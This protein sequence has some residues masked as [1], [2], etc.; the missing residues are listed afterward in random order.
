VNVIGV[1]LVENIMFIR[2][3]LC[4]IEIWSVGRNLD[5]NAL[6]VLRNQNGNLILQPILSVNICEV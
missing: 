3:V 4:D 5:F 2:V 6:I 1:Q